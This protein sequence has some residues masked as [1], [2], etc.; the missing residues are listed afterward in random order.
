[1]NNRTNTHQGTKFENLF[2]DTILDQPQAWQAILESIGHGIL[3]FHENASADVIGGKH[4]KGDVNIKFVQAATPTIRATIKS[5]SSGGYNHLERRNL[6]EF[7]DR[8][9]ISKS[10]THFLKD[11]WLRKA[12]NSKKGKLV[13]SSEQDRVRVIFSSIEPAV[14]AVLGNDHPQIMGLLQR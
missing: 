10:D 9:Q 2:A 8:N 14:S 6:I 1:M 3:L 7:C 5:F 12:L 4:R 13:E 11:L